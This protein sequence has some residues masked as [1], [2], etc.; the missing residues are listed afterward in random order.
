MTRVCLD[1]NPWGA[2]VIG[3]GAYGSSLDHALGYPRLIMASS[4][5]HF[6]YLGMA[7]TYHGARNP[8]YTGSLSRMEWLVYPCRSCRD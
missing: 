6:S 2:G 4:T 5:T 3:A 1:E 8:D 7:S